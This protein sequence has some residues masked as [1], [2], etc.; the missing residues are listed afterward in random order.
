M[1]NVVSVVVGAILF[2]C[3]NIIVGDLCNVIAVKNMTVTL[4][5]LYCQQATEQKKKQTCLN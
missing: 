4:W 1:L 2:N 5:K 3:L